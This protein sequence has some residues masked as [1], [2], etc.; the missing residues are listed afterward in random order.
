VGRVLPVSE[1]EVEI[2]VESASVV[3]TLAS[4]PIVVVVGVVA[5]VPLVE[6]EKLD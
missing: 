1:S 6:R 3:V 4:G 2:V 5:V